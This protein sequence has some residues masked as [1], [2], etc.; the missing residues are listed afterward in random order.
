ML[1]QSQDI[2]APAAGFATVGDS[3]NACGMAGNNGVVS[4]GDGGS[5][6]LQFP[7]PVSNG[8]G[9]DFAVF[10]NSFSDDYL[11]LAF[12]EVSSDGINYYRFASI[13]TTQDTMQV[14]TF[15]LLNASHIN[16]LAGKY[17]INYG[18]PFDLQE[19]SGINGLDINHIT[20]IKII[21]VVGSLV[22]SLASFDSQGRKINDPWPTPFTSS[23]FDLDAVGVFHQWD[24]T[25]IEDGNFNSL[26]YVFPN[27]YGLE[28]FFH[29]Y[30]SLPKSFTLFTL[31]GD[32]VFKYDFSHDE[33][34]RQSIY[35]PVV[36]VPSG[37]YCVQIILEI[38]RAHV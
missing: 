19:L 27:Q 21:D 25:G 26:F 1:F 7:F 3:T 4:L 32:C 23:G 2:S 31:T 12:V 29:S 6:I 11:E 10:E 22:D 5:A 37:I 8:Q 17:R 30:I 34:I 36:G 38:G 15:G 16:N 33:K 35:L 9:Y 20:H 13:T 24:E 18:T 28:L 14:G